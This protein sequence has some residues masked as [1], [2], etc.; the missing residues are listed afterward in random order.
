MISSRHRGQIAEKR[1]VQELIKKGFRI[2]GCDV[3]Y[4]GVQVDVVCK[5]ENVIYLV[6]VKTLKNRAYAHLR[7]SQFQHQRLLQVAD[8]LAACDQSR[9]ELWLAFVDCKN[10]VEMIPVTPA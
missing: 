1:V 4:W 9:V 3:S 2:V 8:N 7:L 6:E 10:A 5:K